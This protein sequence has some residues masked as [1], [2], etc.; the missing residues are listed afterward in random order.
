M[1]EKYLCRFRI[2]TVVD[3]GSRYRP[4]KVV[5]AGPRFRFGESSDLQR[6][7]P[8]PTPPVVLANRAAIGSRED[9]SI[10]IGTSEPRSTEMLGENL[11][12]C[13]RQAYPSPAR[14][15]FRRTNNGPSVIILHHDLFDPHP[16][17]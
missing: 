5:K 6:R 1:A 17:G 4:S 12:Q 8:D 11:Y 16:A 10:K 2:V 3:E 14:I 13:L 15:R 7:E 9:V